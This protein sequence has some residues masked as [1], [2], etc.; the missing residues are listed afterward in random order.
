[1]TGTQ[2][3]KLEE[4]CKKYEVDFNKAYEKYQE[5]CKTMSKEKAFET[6][7]DMVIAWEV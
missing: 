2:I 5:L 6:I 4:Y 3:K 1:M 7:L